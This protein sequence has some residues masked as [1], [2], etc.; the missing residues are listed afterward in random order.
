MVIGDAAKVAEA[1]KDLAAGPAMWGVWGNTSE[2][3]SSHCYKSIPGKYPYNF[4]DLVT[5][6]G[7]QTTPSCSIQ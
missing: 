7:K 4:L 2:L 3:L 5:P 6:A 1:A